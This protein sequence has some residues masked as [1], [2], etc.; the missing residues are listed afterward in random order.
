MSHIEN[1]LEALDA[2]LPD[3]CADKDL[4]EHLPNI[5]KSLSTVH[6][7]RYRGQVPPYFSIEPNIYYLREDVICWLRSRYQGNEE[8][9]SQE[10]ECTNNHGGARR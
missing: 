4:V 9:L 5:F 2:E 6:R 10:K 1:F 7:M 8:S 3:I